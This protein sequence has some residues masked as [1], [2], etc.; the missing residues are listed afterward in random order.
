M[1]WAAARASGATE[2]CTGAPQGERLPA[3]VT[4][5]LR[6]PLFTG[7]GTVLLTP[8]VLSEGLPAPSPLGEL[9]REVGR[10]RGPWWGC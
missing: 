1:S 3:Q 10:Q 4:F 7:A 8:S 6:G 2:G 9:C 5:L